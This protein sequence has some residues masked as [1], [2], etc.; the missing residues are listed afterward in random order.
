MQLADAINFP[1]AEFL[2]DFEDGSPEWHEMRTHGVGGSEVGTIA[3]LNPWESAYALWAKRSGKIPNSFTGNTATRIGKLL[4]APILEM[5][6]QDHPELELLKAG[7]YR[8]RTM[9]I[10]HANPD[11][12]ARHRET[13]EWFVIEVKTA[14]YT[15]DYVPHHYVAQVQHYLDVMGIK[16]AY[17]VALTGM[18]PFE[19]IIEADEFQQGVQRNMALEFWDGLATDTAPAWDGSE[20][21]YQAV[22]AM[23]PLIEETEVN[24]TDLYAEL[25]SAQDSFTASEA[26]LKE[27]KS[28]LLDRMGYAKTAYVELDQDKTMRVASRQ[29]RGGTPTL[30]LDRKAL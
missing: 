23:H 7:T 2:G 4:E 6:A 21:T 29:I 16:R 18:I 17:I 19:Q 13:G 28:K 24:V 9:P 26:A 1:E 11:A 20:S 3:G 22:R 27:V 14:K 12:L 30:I 8:S 5:F 15:W 25:L 10:L